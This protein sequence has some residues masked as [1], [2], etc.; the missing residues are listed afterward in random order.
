MDSTQRGYEL[1]LRVRVFLGSKFDQFIPTYFFDST[2]AP[3]LRVRVD[4]AVFFDKIEE[5]ATPLFESIL[6]A[7]KNQNFACDAII[8]PP[9]F[10]QQANQEIKDD[11]AEHVTGGAKKQLTNEVIGTVASSAIDNSLKSLSDDL[12]LQVW[13]CS[14][15]DPRDSGERFDKVSKWFDPNSLIDQLKKC[16]PGRRI[17][18]V[19]VWPEVMV[20]SGH[21][22]YQKLLKMAQES[23]VT[24]LVL[25]NTVLSAWG[26]SLSKPAAQYRDSKKKSGNNNPDDEKS[27]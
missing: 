2:V 12:P 20:K 11:A 13:E 8:V 6:Y 25:D 5:T 1:E 7:P 15:T 10:A 18:A 3:P 16:H 4:N 26:I 23:N 24:M 22:T 27:E 19:L 9:M 17:I 14:V 21:T